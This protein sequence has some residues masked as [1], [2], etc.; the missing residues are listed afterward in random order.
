MAVP[1]LFHKHIKPAESRDGLFDR[2]LDCFD[3]GSV[4]L[5]RDG[6]SATEFNRFGL[7]PRP[8]SRPSHT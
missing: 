5:N 2:T 4:R 8:R 3:V 1:A 7:R 6:L